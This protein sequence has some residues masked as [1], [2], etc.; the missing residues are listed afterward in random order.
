MPLIRCTSCAYANAMDAKVCKKC[1]REL[2]VPPHLTRCAH[3]GTL[4]PVKGTACVWCYRKLGGSW[5][6]R[7]LGRPARGAAAA[8]AVALLAVLGYYAYPRGLPREAPRPPVAPPIVPA[9]PAPEPVAKAQAGTQAPR[10]ERQP[11]ETSRAKA[12]PVRQA[13]ARK[14]GEPSERSDCAEGVAALGL[15]GKT[16]AAQPPRPQACTEAVAALGLCD[17]RNI[18]GRE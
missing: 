8:A 14:A 13:S 2:S 15:C 4:N 12:A 17:A 7:L 1:G 3:C 11:G 10:V 18:K 16:Q 9:A 6:R 5:Q